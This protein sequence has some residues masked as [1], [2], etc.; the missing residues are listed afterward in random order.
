VH[1]Y[2]STHTYGSTMPNPQLL[3]EFAGTAFFVF[4]AE[5]I[6]GPTSTIPALMKPLVLSCSLGALTFCGA[7][8]SGSHYNPAVTVAVSMQKRF[9][10]PLPALLMYSGCQLLGAFTGVLGASFITGTTPELPITASHAYSTLTHH[11]S[12]HGIFGPGE[13]IPAVVVEALFTCALVFVFLNSLNATEHH[14]V[15]IAI[16]A[17][18]LAGHCASATI[19]GGCLNPAYATALV[20]NRWFCAWANGLGDLSYQGLWV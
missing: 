4:T 19:S 11:E 13:F 7:A 2:L 15:G 1:A 5:L 16:G 17:T 14:I 8:I 9:A 10:A 3:C 20:L 6:R 12:D 18:Y